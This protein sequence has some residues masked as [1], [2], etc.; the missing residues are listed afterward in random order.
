MS[1]PDVAT[2]KTAPNAIMKKAGSGTLTD[3][4]LMLQK[5]IDFFG[6]R[7]TRKALFLVVS[8]PSKVAAFIEYARYKVV[9][10]TY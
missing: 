3:R 7:T 4:I 5:E 2:T 9:T 1:F 6:N 10:T 8:L